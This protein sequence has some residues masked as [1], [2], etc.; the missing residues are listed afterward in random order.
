MGLIGGDGQSLLAKTIN[1]MDHTSSP[2]VVFRL[3]Y[4]EG[5]VCL[6]V[7]DGR[8]WGEYF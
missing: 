7:W 8:V 3:L 5:G 4:V 2:R 6:C 1:K